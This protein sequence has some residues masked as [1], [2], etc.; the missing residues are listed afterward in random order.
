MRC[1][2]AKAAYNDLENAAAS[3]DQESGMSKKRML[4]SRM[5]AYCG[6]TPATTE[7]HVVPTCLFDGPLPPDIVKVPACNAC[8]H[9]KSKDDGYLRDILIT[10]MHCSDYPIAQALIGGKFKRAMQKNRSDFA[11]AAVRRGCLKPMYSS[12]GVYL[13]HFHS[14]PLE[15]ARVNQIFSTIARGLYFKL[16]GQ[17]FPDGYS[18]EVMRVEPSRA[19]QA[20]D[21]MKAQ[22]ANGPYVLGRV[23]ACL[24]MFAAEDP[25][26]TL[27]LMQ[28]YGGM[29][30]TVKTEQ[31]VSSEVILLPGEGNK[32]VGS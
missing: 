23:F 24:V 22:G 25:G 20:I 13:G 10:D 30:V 3:I 14:V 7:D 26:V 19:Q 29:F 31:T 6:V 12:G 28:F 32:G 17:R 1:A 16:R 21:V 4:G 27:W 15:V 8:N 11:R 5:C 9:A 18:F 2:I